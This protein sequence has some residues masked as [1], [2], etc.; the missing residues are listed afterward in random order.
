M[1]ALGWGKDPYGAVAGWSGSGASIAS[2]AVGVATLTGL[3]N[4]SPL[5]IGRNITLYGADT[6]GNNGTFLIVDYVSV[7]SIKISN[8]NA[9]SPDATDGF[10]GWIE[11]IQNDESV[12]GA[13]AAGIGTSILS[14]LALATNEVKVVLS[15][16]P[17]HSSVFSAG[18]A[19]NPSTWAIQRLDT[20][21]FL[22]VLSVRPINPLTYGLTTLESF[23]SVLVTHRVSSST[24]LD[25]AG[26]SLKT[27]RQADFLGLLDASVSTEEKK[28]YKHRGGSRDLFNSP[29][30]ID[31]PSRFGGTLIIN[32]VGD[33]QDM[34]GDALIKKLILRRLLSHP[35][36]FFHL[37]EY[38]IGFRNKEPVFGGGLSRIKAE[39]ERQVLQE[40]EVD[41]AQ[42]SLTLDANTLTVLVRAKL[43]ASGTQLSVSL[44]LRSDGMTF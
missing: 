31:D 21:A 40:P 36:D 23:G 20:T 28:T 13:A 10:I 37:P 16:E 7:S 33:Y 12:N 2:V 34:S 22:H 14:A 15:G 17:R 8:V 32:S 44:P 42:A 43:R 38:G 5:S 39:I 11:R 35:G 24:L 29:T 41:V 19:L 1:P 26:F 25:A 4:M 3:A 27:P 9:V 6:D 18:D 30:P